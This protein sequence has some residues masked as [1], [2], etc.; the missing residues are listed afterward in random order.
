MKCGASRRKSGGH[1]I[2]RKLLFVFLL[3]SASAAQAV[4]TPATI[5]P[6]AVQLIRPH[7]SVAAVSG[8]LGCAPTEL[9]P[10]TRFPFGRWIWAVP[11]A[12]ANSQGLE[13]Q[14]VGVAIDEAGVMFAIYTFAPLVGSRPGCNGALRVEPPTT[15]H[16]NWVPGTCP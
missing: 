6:A 11:R 4:C 15:T 9:P 14:E 7:M 16:G 1:Q 5:N 12:V 13:Y 2:M 3:A 10:P 8:V